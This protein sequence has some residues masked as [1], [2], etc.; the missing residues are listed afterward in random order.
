MKENNEDVNKRERK[1]SQG[2]GEDQDR[3]GA[4]HE[5]AAEDVLEH[6]RRELRIETVGHPQIGVHLG[7]L[8][9]DG[10]EPSGFQAREGG[11]HRVPV[12]LLVLGRVEAE[13]LQVRFPDSSRWTC[14]VGT[15]RS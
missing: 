9:H 15:R 12:H 14:K 4:G 13:G 6:A 5:V 7:L 3:V 11:Y 10:G 8:D 2:A 1:Y